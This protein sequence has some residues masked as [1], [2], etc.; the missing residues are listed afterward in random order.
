M[1][2]VGAGP[3][4]CAT[5]ITAAKRGAS[6]LLVD[7][8]PYGRWKVCGGCVSRLGCEALATLGIPSELLEAESYPLNRLRLS[9]GA[10]QAVLRLRGGRAISRTHLDPLLIDHAISRGAAYVSDGKVTLTNAGGGADWVSSTVTRGEKTMEVKARCV[11]WAGGLQSLPAVSR[12]SMTTKIKRNSYVGLGATL[13]TAHSDV[14][15]GVVD[16]HVTRHGYIGRV[17]LPDGRVDVA[18][19]VNPRRLKVGESS[20][21]VMG[22]MLRGVPGIPQQAIDDARQA[23]W[24]GTPKLTMRSTRLVHGR[25]FLVGDAAGYIEPFTGEGMGWALSSGIELGAILGDIALTSERQSL[26]DIHRRWSKAHKQCVRRRQSACHAIRWGLRQPV[27]LRGLLRAANHLPRP[28]ENYAAR[29]GAPDATPRPAANP[30]RA[31][32]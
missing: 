22:E 20:A 28:F 9:C 25:V 12:D 11:A 8:Q 24:R 30:E 1:L 21:Q 6:V 31:T 23:R 29:V 15:P 32:A 3:A 4:G 27:L 26:P 5:A 19:A 17:L 13:D 16:M 10:S 18:A 7:K 14:P 2:V